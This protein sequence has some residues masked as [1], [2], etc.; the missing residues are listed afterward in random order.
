MNQ[1]ATPFQE[2]PPRR[3][4]DETISKESNPRCKRRQNCRPYVLPPEGHK[5]RQSKHGY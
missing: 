5:Q 4:S 2:R 3:C 1:E